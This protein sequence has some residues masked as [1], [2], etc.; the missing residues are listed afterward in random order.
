MSRICQGLEEQVDAFRK[1]PLERRLPYLWLDA[2]V[3]GVRDGGRVVRK[4]PVLGCRMRESG[5]RG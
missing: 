1:W 2:K 4:A 3:G 5:Y